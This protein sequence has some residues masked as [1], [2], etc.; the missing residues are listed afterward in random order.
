MGIPCFKWIIRYVRS[1][2]ISRVVYVSFLTGHIVS[3]GKYQWKWRRITWYILRFDTFADWFACNTSLISVSL[4]IAGWLQSLLVAG[5]MKRTIR[6]IIASDTTIWDPLYSVVLKPCCGVPQ[7][8]ILIM[9]AHG[10]RH[11]VGVMPLQW[12]WH[13]HLGWLVI[14][15]TRFG[16]V[17]CIWEGCMGRTK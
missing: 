16:L 10:G 11:I 15:V 7:E 3:V 17:H 1:E 8:E 6:P 13:W 5:A 4:L 9:W 14:V 2:L 12:Y